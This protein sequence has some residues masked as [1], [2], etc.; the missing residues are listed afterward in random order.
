MGSK[1]GSLVGSVQPGPKFR[2]EIVCNAT[3]KHQVEA[4]IT[5]ADTMDFITLC[6][7]FSGK[8][9]AIWWNNV[10]SLSHYNLSL[11][12]FIHDS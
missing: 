4:P 12:I 1:E 10:S 8:N 3:H 5:G 7:V 6:G 11:L 2:F 9:G